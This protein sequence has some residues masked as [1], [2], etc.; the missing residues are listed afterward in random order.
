[1]T[2]LPKFLVDQFPVT[3]S[4]HGGIHALLLLLFAFLL[5]GV[6]TGH[7]CIFDTIAHDRAKQTASQEYEGGGG[8]RLTTAPM[9]P[10]RTVVHSVDL[11][12]VRGANWV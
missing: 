5:S 2:R 9:L 3:M 4:F 12:T 1:M 6:V 11:G 10:L 7:T 8:R